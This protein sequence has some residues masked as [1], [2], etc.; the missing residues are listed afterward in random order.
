[1][2][3]AAD[4][5]EGLPAWPGV[6]ESPGM[7]SRHRKELERRRSEKVAL[8]AGEWLGWSSICPHEVLR[9]SSQK[10]R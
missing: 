7:N 1:M 3:G 4:I 2:G 10:P 8:E 6:S 5:H 9:A